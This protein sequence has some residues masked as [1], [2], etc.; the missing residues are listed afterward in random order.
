MLGKGYIGTRIWNELKK[1]G[2]EG[3]LSTVHRYIAGVREETRIKGLVTTRV[4]TSAGKQMQYDWKEWMLPINGRPVKVYIHEIILSYSRRKYYCSSLSITTADIIRAITAA[5]GYFGGLAEELVID[6][7]KQMVIAHDRNGIIRYNDEFLRFLGLYGIDSR[8]CSTYRARTKGK[9]E[10]PFY[11]IQE[12]LLRGLEVGDIA[13][14]DRLLFE[15]TEQYNARPHSDLKESPDKRFEIEKG[16][17]RPIPV[18]EPASLYTRQ[19]RTVSS[20]GY[21]SWDS[22]LYPVSMKHCLKKVMVE[23]IF[24]KTLRVY[25]IDG[26]PIA[27][28]DIRLADRHVRPVHPEHGQIND[29]YSKKKAL[30]KSDVVKRFVETF[31][32][33][34]EAFLRGLKTAVGANMYWHIEEIMRYTALYST[35]DIISVMEECTECNSYHKNSIM[36]LLKNKPLKEQ[37]VETVNS[38]YLGPAIDI[39]RPLSTYHVSAEA[40]I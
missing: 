29:S 26:S 39:N 4:E 30:Y 24:G 16:A 31:K 11:Y 22:A 34:G 36:R 19:I 27:E 40:S 25:A 23:S 35:E 5:I 21:I 18:V 6:N 37:P 17:L 15:F 38:P 10:R 32:E 12:H 33:A 9:V 20:D 7:P 2:Y 13:E 28:I 3:S 14:F 8:P 1:G